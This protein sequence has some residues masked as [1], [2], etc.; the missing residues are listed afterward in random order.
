LFRCQVQVLFFQFASI[1]TSFINIEKGGN[2]YFCFWIKLSR[3]KRDEKKFEWFTFL[4]MSSPRQ[5][6]R[7]SD[8]SFFL[9]LLLV[10]PSLSFL[11]WILSCCF[12]FHLLELFRLS[13]YLSFS[14]LLSF[15]RVK[16]KKRK[17]I[18]NR[19]FF[20]KINLTKIC[21]T[22]TVHKKLIQNF[23]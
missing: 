16:W 15:H 12:L 4:T 23:V 13:M 18:L 8:T 5:N 22:W 19:M 14:F 6:E 20:F 11:T 10:H 17:L 7:L 3:E 2:F 21:K 9:L 1:I